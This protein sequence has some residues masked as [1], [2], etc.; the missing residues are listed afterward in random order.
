MENLVLK[1]SVKKSDVEFKVGAIYRW[2]KLNTYYILLRTETCGDEGMYVLF[3]IESGTRYD[4][5]KTKE[6]L[7]EDM[8][9]NGVE[10]IYSSIVVE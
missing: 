10:M 4:L 8:I 7:I 9:D 5:P 1:I 6:R 3:N 2:T